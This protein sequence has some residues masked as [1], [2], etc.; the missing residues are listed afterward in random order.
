MSQTRR[1]EGK[2]CDAVLR[3]LEHRLNTQRTDLH[4]PDRADRTSQRVDVCVALGGERY[5][6]EHTRIEPFVGATETGVFLGEF[7]DP[8]KERLSAPLPGPALYGL[9]L[10]QDPRFDRGGR[11]SQR[12]IAKAQEALAEFVSAEAPSLYERALA[13]GRRGMAFTAQ[14]VPSLTRYYYL[15]RLTCSITGKP[16]ATD[17]G[18]FGAVRIVDDNLEEQRIERLRKALADKCPKLQHCKDRGARTVLVLED[19]DIANS[20][21]VVV[22]EALNRAGE[23]RTDLP[24]EI[25]LVETKVNTWY[26]WPMNSAAVAC[27]PRDFDIECKALESTDLDDL[28]CKRN[29]SFQCEVCLGH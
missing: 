16:S 4:V 27:F 14:E 8:I 28:M 2:C 24:N 18:Q 22:R 9:E 17:T 1:N 23:E 19:D 26:M 29:S 10:P 7:M 21:S 5:V 6:L 15:A 11:G 13:S 3:V 20:N 25:Y 12:R